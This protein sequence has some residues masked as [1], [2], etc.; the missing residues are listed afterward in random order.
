MRPFAF[1]PFFG[2]DGSILM[3][4]NRTATERDMEWFWRQAEPE[5][6]RLIREMCAEDR[7][8]GRR[9]EP[10]ALKAEMEAFTRIR[11]RN[12]QNKNHKA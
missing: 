4:G 1:Y 7:S 12:V 6:D 11:S 9:V 10:W 5:L 3:A 8:Q 2:L